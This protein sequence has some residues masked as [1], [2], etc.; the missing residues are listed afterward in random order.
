M[1]VSSDESRQLER[2]ERVNRIEIEEIDQDGNPIPR[3]PKTFSQKRRGNGGAPRRSYHG[4]RDGG[5]RE[6]GPR[7]NR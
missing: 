4:S 3:A 6:N 2:V 5:G 7:E 1:F